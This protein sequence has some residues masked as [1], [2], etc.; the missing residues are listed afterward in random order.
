MLRCSWR[1]R[2]VI[3]G[4]TCADPPRFVNLPPDQVPGFAIDQL[5]PC[6]C[7]QAEQES[8]RPDAARGPVLIGLQRA[9]FVVKVQSDWAMAAPCHF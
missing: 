4:L 3:M 2:S 7:A 9:D 6:F 5:P 1:K 8:G